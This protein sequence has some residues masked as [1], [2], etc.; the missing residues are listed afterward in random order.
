MGEGSALALAGLFGASALGVVESGAEAA[1]VWV[2][3]AGDVL[4]VG[5]VA[6]RGDQR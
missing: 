6:V 2:V 1:A 3:V 5:A 4:E